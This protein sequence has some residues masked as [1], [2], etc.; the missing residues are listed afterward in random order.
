MTLFMFYVLYFMQNDQS[1]AE[2]L[3]EL[4]SS[5]LYRFS[6]LTLVTALT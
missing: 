3:M 1:D 5:K 4:L 6:T 2:R